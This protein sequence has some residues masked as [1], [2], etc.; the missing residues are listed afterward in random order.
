[1]KNIGKL[2]FIGCVL[3]SFLSKAQES[4]PQNWLGSYKGDLLIYAA[5]S[6]KM[7]LEMEL[8]ISGTNKDSLFD[9]T[10]TYDFKGDKDIRAYKLLVVDRTKGHYKIDER[11]SIVIGNLR[12]T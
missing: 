12:L 10:I 8:N 5:D 2:I 9:W 6:I 11:N 3:I 4:F 7:K 1:M